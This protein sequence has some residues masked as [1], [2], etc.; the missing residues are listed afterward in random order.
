MKRYRPKSGRGF[1]LM[2]SIVAGALVASLTLL[3]FVQYR[4]I[5]RIAEAERE[6]R[7]KEVRL[8]AA[9]FAEEFNGEVLRALAA[10]ALSRNMSNGDGANAYGELYLQW[11]STARTTDSRLLKGCNK[12]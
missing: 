9:R 7:Q 5:G 4:W 8:A 11:A 2:F 10:A 6:R 12:G 1:N 3:A